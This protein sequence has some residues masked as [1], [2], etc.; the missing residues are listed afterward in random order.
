MKQ[1]NKIKNIHPGIVLK[2]EFL[3]PF[4][5]TRSRLAELI[6]M[7]SQQ[8][9]NITTCKEGVSPAMALRLAK[10]FSN[11][12]QFWLGLQNDYDL[13]RLQADLAKQLATIKPIKQPK[14][15]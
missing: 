4:G 14:R 13:T 9:S 6:H 15:N 5:L 10:V 12:P 3:I 8:I 11:T 7:S 1:S 2:E